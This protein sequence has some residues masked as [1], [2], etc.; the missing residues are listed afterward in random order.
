MLGLLFWTRIHLPVSLLGIQY[1]KNPTGSGL[2]PCEHHKHNGGEQDI[3]CDQE[4]GEKRGHA[5][6]I[7]ACAGVLVQPIPL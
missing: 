3:A 7:G 6:A 5:E 4:G 2:G 1:S